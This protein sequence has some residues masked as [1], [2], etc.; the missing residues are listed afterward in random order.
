M[1]KQ[2]YIDLVKNSKEDLLDEK[3]SMT[4]YNKN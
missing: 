3:L 2:V 1:E 4:S